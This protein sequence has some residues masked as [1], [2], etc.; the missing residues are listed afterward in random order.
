M[1]ALKR[2]ARLGRRPPRL[3]EVNRRHEAIAASANSGQVSPAWLAIAQD[4]SKRRDMDFEIAFFDHRIGPNAGHELALCDQLARTLDQRDQ[5]LQSPAA[6]TNPC[7]TF[8]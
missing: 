5:N 3:G 8:Q 7:L 6:E 2:S 4:P 1:R